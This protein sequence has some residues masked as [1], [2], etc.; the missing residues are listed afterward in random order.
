MNEMN[1][2]N[3]DI[4]LIK[5]THLKEAE[6]ILKLLSHPARLQMLNV[7]GQHE[8]NVSEICDLLNLEQSVV[9]HHL[10]TLRKFQLVNTERIGKAIYYH[11][12]DPHI[13]DI[14]AETLEH[15]DHV[16]RGK[17]HGK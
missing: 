14:V 13:L 8:L 4:S 16:L 11:L 7:L 15:A 3:Q 9:S 17:P 10:A 2:S 6:R 12:D 1:F 5:K